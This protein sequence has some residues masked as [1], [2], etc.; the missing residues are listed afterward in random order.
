[1]GSVTSTYMCTYDYC[2]C[3]SDFDIALWDNETENNYWNRT[4]N[5]LDT[6]SYTL[7]YYD[8]LNATTDYDTFYSCYEA[9]QN[10]TDASEFVDK[11]DTSYISL[12]RW[13]ETEYNCSGICTPGLFF[14]F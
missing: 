7:I 12:L 6:L 9:M 3:P 2:P 14:F 4:I 1:M 11:V 5:P 10:N 8:V 13:L